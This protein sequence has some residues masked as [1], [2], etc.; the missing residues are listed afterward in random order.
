[1]EV[2]LLSIGKDIGE[3]TNLA[4]QHPEIVERLVKYIDDFKI[5]LKE[6]KRPCGIMPK[7]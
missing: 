3:T 7:N 2:S 6:N 4:A 5:E 1:M